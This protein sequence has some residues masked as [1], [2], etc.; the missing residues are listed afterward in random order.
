LTLQKSVMTE[1]AIAATV[2]FRNW[3]EY[4]AEAKAG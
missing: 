2:I 1:P 3:I 4:L